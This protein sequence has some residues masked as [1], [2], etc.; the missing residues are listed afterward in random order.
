MIFPRSL[1]LAIRRRARDFPAQVG[2]NHVLDLLLV[3]NLHDADEPAKPAPRF[4]DEALVLR[5]ARRQH[6]ADLRRRT[7]NLVRDVRPAQLHL[8]ILLLRELLADVRFNQICNVAHIITFV[9]FSLT[10]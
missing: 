1:D 10:I 9:N 5:E 2:K 6:V 7:R 8:A 4:D 3:G